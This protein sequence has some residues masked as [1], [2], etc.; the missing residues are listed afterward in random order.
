MGPALL[1]QLDSKLFKRFKLLKTRSQTWLLTKVPTNLHKVADKVGG[2]GVPDSE[3][4]PAQQ[5][6]VRHERVVPVAGVQPG[7]GRERGGGQR[8]LQD[9]DMLTC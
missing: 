8:L 3:A 4:S 1:G 5:P 6:P 2:N 7:L 9:A